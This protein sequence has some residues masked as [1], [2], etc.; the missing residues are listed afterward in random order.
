M[1]NMEKNKFEEV[2]NFVKN[3][4]EKSNIEITQTLDKLS[5][6]F[7]YTKVIIIDLTY[8]LDKIEELYKTIL[9]EYNKRQNG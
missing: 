7:N 9:N 1:D 2:I 3:I 5:E 6:D 8:D 4:K